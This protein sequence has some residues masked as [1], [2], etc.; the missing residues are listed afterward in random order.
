MDFFVE[1]GARGILPLEGGADERLRTA[2]LS[3]QNTNSHRPLATAAFLN[4]VHL[5]N[6]EAS[7]WT[8][9]VCSFAF[10]TLS[11]PSFYLRLKQKLR[12]IS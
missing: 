11:P 9:E 4:R 5:E 2:C 7:V 6:T 12:N 10:N 1:V 3:G 8:R